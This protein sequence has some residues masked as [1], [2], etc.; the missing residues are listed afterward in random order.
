M[1]IQMPVMDGYTASRKIRE[2]PKF[3]ELPIIAMTANAMAGDREKA[4]ETGMNDHVAKPIDVQELFGVLVKWIKPG[5]REPARTASAERG[6]PEPEPQLPGLAGIDIQQGLDRLGGNAKLYRSILLKFRRNQAGAALEIEEALNQADFELAE[7]LAHTAKGVSGNIGA[8]D[9]HQASIG[10]DDALKS[11]DEKQARELIPVFAKELAVVVEAIA[12]LEEEEHSEPQEAVAFD[13]GQL[14]PVIAELKELLEDDDTAASGKLEHL[15]GLLRGS[16][17][18]SLLDQMG[19]QIG[20]YEF[21]EA[22]DSLS[23]LCES[24]NLP[25][26]G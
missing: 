24:L 25:L 23:E 15:A 8:D 6:G 19:E 21:E 9:L 14:M 11:H 10:L 13:P 3:A 2:N 17:S 18:K 16:P 5:G 12:A 4:L 7:R 1:D 20:G 22:L 26:E